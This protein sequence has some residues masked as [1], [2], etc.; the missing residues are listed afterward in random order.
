MLQRFLAFC[1]QILEMILP[2][3]ACSKQ[4][5]NAWQSGETAIQTEKQYFILPRISFLL[6]SLPLCSLLSQLRA[7]CI[8]SRMGNTSW[9]TEGVD[10][11]VRLFNASDMTDGFRGSQITFSL[12]ILTL[13]WCIDTIGNEGSSRRDVFKVP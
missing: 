3:S 13:S 2:L 9:G 5:V 8:V 4:A 7:S 1:R 11:P 6:N 12:I 10:V